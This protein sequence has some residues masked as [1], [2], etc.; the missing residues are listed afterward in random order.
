MVTQAAPGLRAT[1]ELWRSSRTPV[2]PRASIWRRERAH[3]PP[4][5]SWTDDSTASTGR[6]AHGFQSVTHF[7]SREAGLKTEVE[8]E[9]GRHTALS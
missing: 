9:S 8:V 1:V 2:V 6:L 7:V 4:E 3:P 5:G